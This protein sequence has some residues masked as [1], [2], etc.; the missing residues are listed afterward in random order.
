M[1]RVSRA[2]SEGPCHDSRFRRSCRVYMCRLNA[3]PAVPRASFGVGYFLCFE[4]ATP[5]ESVFSRCVRSYCARHWMRIRSIFVVTADDILHLGR[6]PTRQEKDKMEAQK[7][8]LAILPEDRRV[9][10]L[11]LLH[12]R[13]ADKRRQ[14]DEVERARKRRAAT[15]IYLCLLELKQ[16]VE[17]AGAAKLRLD[18]CEAEDERRQVRFYRW[19]AA[20]YPCVAGR[21][22]R[23]AHSYRP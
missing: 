22:K 16:P 13:E 20:V 14:R 11:A 4:C 9:E 8:K 21:P 10:A 2:L 3:T 19:Y 18:M 1:L 17:A 6:A 15:G 5:I 7:R 12:A 23:C